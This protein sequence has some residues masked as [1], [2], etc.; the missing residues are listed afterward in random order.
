MLPNKEL[1][2]ARL[3]LWSASFALQLTA[4]VGIVIGSRIP[5]SLDGERTMTWVSILAGCGLI[6]IIGGCD[7]SV[8]IAPCSEIDPVLAASSFIMVLTPADGARTPSPIQV[9]GCS[10]TSESNI[11]WK[12]RGR[13][14]R[15]LASGFA[16]GGGFSG[17]AVFEFS[18]E[19]VVSEAEVGRLEL[20]APDESEGE[21]F[22]PAQTILPL[23]LIPGSE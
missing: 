14:G 12:L 23:V 21:G 3:D 10:R 19:Y 1:L 5:M 9:T 13:D 8:P 18:A 15:V 11:L 7:G 2:L 17:T 6:G 16:S 22:P 20:S 4:R